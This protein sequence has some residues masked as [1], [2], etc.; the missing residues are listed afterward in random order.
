MKRIIT[1]LT[2]NGIGWTWR[3]ATDKYIMY[4]TNDEGEGLFQ[5]DLILNSRKQLE[6]TC[7]FSLPVDEKAARRKILRWY[8]GD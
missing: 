1:D 3:F 4:G 2:R 7:D 5:V 8:H 6:G